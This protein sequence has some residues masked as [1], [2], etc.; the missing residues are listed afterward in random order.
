MEI[1][2]R[3]NDRVRHLKELGQSAA[4]RRETGEFLAEGTK[5]F[6]EALLRGAEIHE[7]LYAGR[8]PLP[9]PAGAQLYSCP[10]EILEYVSPMKNPQDI[11]FSCRIPEEG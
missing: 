7:I 6:R 1:T 10:K 5:L 2:S 9:V 8:E 4:C 11:L 3:R